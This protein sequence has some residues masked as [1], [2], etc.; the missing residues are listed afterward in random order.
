MTLYQP[1]PLRGLVS[2]LA[3]GTRTAGSAFDQARARI[4][5][6]EEFVKAWI[7]IEGTASQEAAGPLHGVPL[8]VKDIIDVRGYS[9]RCGSQLHANIAPAQQDASI[10]RRWSEAGALPLGK[11]VTT[12][13]AYFAPGPTR[14]PAAPGH[15]PGGSSS[16]SAAA[17]A[18]GQVPIAIGSQTAGSVTR[19]AS[20]CGVASLVMSQGR[21]ATDGIVGLSPAFDSHGIFTATV[22]DLALAWSAISGEQDQA[23]KQ[24]RAPRVAWWSAKN[25]NVVDEQMTAA[26]RRTREIIEEAGGTIEELGNE[27]LVTELIDL[28]RIVM[29]VEA[30]RERVF[31]AAHPGGLSLQFA[32]LLRNG[33]MYAAGRYTSA[34]ER[35]KRAQTAMD[36]VFKE[37]DVIIGPAAPGAAP[38]GIDATGDP[39]LS[40]PWQAMALPVV[41]VPGLRSSAGLPLGLQVIGAPN[42]ESAAISSALW[43]E[44]VIARAAAPTGAR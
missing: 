6:T 11:T 29:A 7:D 27:Q 16:G 28:H 37:F 17:V 13:F 5:E 39:V 12:E 35:I 44:K 24:L 23:G 18:S 33:R 32:E 10:V 2:D 26:L 9:T 25:L 30:A 8:G 34:L 15:T 20:Y 40:R 4:G 19:P 36:E 21:F 3:D 42:G 22:D 43:L 38:E 31:E 41:T 14:N 1:W